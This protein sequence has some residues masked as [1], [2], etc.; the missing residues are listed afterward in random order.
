MS[1]ASNNKN[2]TMGIFEK[3]YENNVW[4]NLN[5]EKLKQTE[6][7]SG[8]GST[9]KQTATIIKEIPILLKKLNIKSILDAPCG[10]FNW[11]KEIDLSN[12][13]Y[14]GIDIV[15]IVINDNNKKYQ[16]NNRKF[17]HMDV[18]S[19]NL[20]KCDLILCRD[21]LVHFTIDG[22][23]E[24]V[25]NFKKSGAKYLLTTTFF[26]RP[27]KLD[28]SLGDWNPY[29]LLR[30]PFNFPKPLSIINE[31]CTEAN[32]EYNDKSLV[33]WNLNDLNF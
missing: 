5:D 14:I 16:S 19:D 32:N 9:L 29:D 23:F 24:A 31:N 33:L 18:L 8:G 1:T 27:N 4:Y 13:N 25:R 20:P 22:V 21:C 17:M 28:A 10:D 3:I 30:H 2:K 15:P 6:S 11:M 26:N 12:I 7:K